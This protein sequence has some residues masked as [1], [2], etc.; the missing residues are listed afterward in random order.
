MT[1]A[2]NHR[3]ATGSH[4]T[5]EILADFVARVLLDAWNE[6]GG[7]KKCKVIDPA[8]GN[9]QLLHSLLRQIPKEMRD[10]VYVTG[11]DIDSKALARAKDRIEGSFP[12]VGAK[13]IHAD[14]LKTAL[15]HNL[16]ILFEEPMEM[17]D[18][19]IANPPYVRTQ[20]MGAAQAQQLAKQFNLAGRVDL[21]FAFLKC[22]ERVLRPGGLASIIVTNRFMTT[23]A[24]ASV[25]KSLVADFDILH[26]WDLGD[27]RLFEAAVLP[28]VLLLQKKNGNTGTKH[29]RFT[30]I[31]STVATM[32]HTAPNLI[33]AL[34]LEGVVQIEGEK[35]FMVRRGTLDSADCV[36]KIANFASDSWNAKVDAHTYCTFGEIGK[37]RV[38]VK[39]TADKVFV[40]TDWGKEDERPELLKPLITHKV[41]RP[42][43]AANLNGDAPLILYTHES[44]D[45]KRRV[46]D[47]AK[48]PKS[49]R[50][51]ETHRAI[52]EARS[53]VIEAGRQWFEIW[54]PQQ[55]DL[56]K[57]PK[58]VFPDICEKP[59]FML[60]LE[61]SVVQ[62]DSY[63]LISEKG[64]DIVWLALAVGNSSFIEAFYDHRFNN[65]LYAGRRRMMTQYVEKFPIPN[66]QAPISKKLIEGAKLVHQLTPSPKADILARELDHQVWLAF[67][68][69]GKDSRR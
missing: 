5:P 65:K 45:G 56:W 63:W 39:T 9:G 43:K 12:G 69:S 32:E 54:V 66:P 48:Y 25:R 42:F 34:E 23:R 38:G 26:V 16:G 11:Y 21:A 40:R 17:F 2:A 15:N 18:M 28:A 50:Y 52:L 24:G 55:P 10:S 8:V 44:V 37:I 62:G 27:T 30:S 35:R 29:P 33:A 20:V 3:K 7:S 51:L 41:A 49:K 53:Y 1:K 36:W 4:F 6:H 31:Y 61:G 67:G 68:F 59:T 60:D 22:I 64:D 58:L 14:F 57:H 19:A 46:V 13:W 47:L